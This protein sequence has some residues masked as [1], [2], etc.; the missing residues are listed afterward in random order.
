Q[1]LLV[2]PFFV[3]RLAA[4]GDLSLRPSLRRVIPFLAACLGVTWLAYVSFGPPLVASLGDALTHVYLSG[5]ALNLN[6]ILAYLL[7]LFR[8]DVF[9]TL[10]QG[11]AALRHET[12]L[13]AT[14]HPLLVLPQRV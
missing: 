14:T 1:P 6:W 11:P 3:I 12:L 13:I 4:D 10:T 8:P 9:G 7:H 2:A 5:N